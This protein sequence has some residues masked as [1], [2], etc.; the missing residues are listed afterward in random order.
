MVLV[1]VVNK[2]VPGL[3][4]EVLPAWIE[5]FL[6]FLWA[7]PVL[8]LSL[9][10]DPHMRPH[11]LVAVIHSPSLQCWESSMELTQVHVYQLN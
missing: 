4:E 1:C 7:H 2:E 10:C 3:F 9:L 6:A 5:K 11:I 8:A